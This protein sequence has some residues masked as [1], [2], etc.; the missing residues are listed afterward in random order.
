MMSMDDLKLLMENSLDRMDS[1]HFSHEIFKSC[2]L[3]VVRS[4]FERVEV[5]AWQKTWTE[6][7]NSSLIDRQVNQFNPVELLDEPPRELMDIAKHERILDIM[8]KIHGPNIGLFR[9]RFMIKDRYSLN[10]RVP[11]HDD[12][13]YQIGWPNKA[14][15]FLALTPA[16]EKNGCMRFYPGTHKFGY[17]G[18]AG[19]INK[20][21]LG[22]NWPSVAPALDPGDFVIMNSSTWHESGPYKSG[23][24]R[25]MTDFIY[26][27]AEDFSTKEIVRGDSV[28]SKNFMNSESDGKAIKP[29][30][31]TIKITDNFFIQS[32][33]SK[34]KELH[35]KID[36]LAK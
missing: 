2:G 3:F 9:T 24:D 10:H 5:S 19:E 32:R 13:S 23:P 7:Y 6:F 21:I 29:D 15:V 22:E 8:E 11:L 31:R 16:N 36:A 1:I 34:L 18:D 27:S 4:A 14:S 17:L 35:Q 26:Q 12:F 25:V 28:V 33:T 30:K 20:E